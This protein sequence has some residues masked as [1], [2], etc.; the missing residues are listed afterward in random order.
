MRYGDRGRRPSAR[1]TRRSVSAHGLWVGTNIE[2]SV[3]IHREFIAVGLADDHR[4]G[5][6]AV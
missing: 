3:A 6:P 5:R 4:P 2:F 1:S